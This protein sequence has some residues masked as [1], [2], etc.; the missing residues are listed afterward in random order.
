MNRRR[1]L[2]IMGMAGVAA[3][4]PWQFNL[5]RGLRF[6]HAYAFSQ[7]PILP[8]FVDSLPGLTS[9]GPIVSAST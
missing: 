2:K 1:F 3:A 6:N 5:R 9:A 7:T 8:K 4:I